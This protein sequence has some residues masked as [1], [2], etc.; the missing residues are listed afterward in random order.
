M[1]RVPGQLERCLMFAN[2]KVCVYE[3]LPKITKR[4]DGFDNTETEVRNRETSKQV[5]RF[6]VLFTRPLVLTIDKS[7]NF[8]NIVFAKPCGRLDN[9]KLYSVFESGFLYDHALRQSICHWAGIFQYRSNYW[10]ICDLQH[11]LLDDVISV[12]NHSFYRSFNYNIFNMRSTR[13]PCALIIFRQIC[14]ISPIA[15]GLSVCVSVKIIRIGHTLAKIKKCC[16]KWRL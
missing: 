8:L 2:R 13:L 12:E 9:L 14:K 11:Y 10:F 7:L 1:V 3:I 16:K 6:R 4:W 5:S 15:M